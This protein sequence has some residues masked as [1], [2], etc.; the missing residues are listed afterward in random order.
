M[1]TARSDAR[2]M[3]RSGP[4]GE[5]A[6]GFGLLPFYWRR[7]ELDLPTGARNPRNEANP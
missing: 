6:R 1:Q 5:M 2:R 3:R 4:F 7:R